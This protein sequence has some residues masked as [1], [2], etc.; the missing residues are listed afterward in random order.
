MNKFFATL[1]KESLMLLRDVPG[2]A[3]LFIMPVLLILV[4]TLA[5][6]NALKFQGSANPIL[7][8]DDHPTQFSKTLATN[9][10]SSGMFSVVRRLEG[11]PI[12]REVANKLLANGSYKL[13]LII[14]KPDDEIVILTDPT[15]QPAY[16]SAVLG[17]LN[18]LIRS[19]QSRYAIEGMLDVTAGTMKPV[20]ESMIDEALANLPP[21]TTHFALKERSAIQPNPIQNNVPGFILFAMF[22]IVIPLS[23]SIINEKN[24]GGYQRLMTLPVNV[25]TILSG[26]IVLYLIVCLLQFGVMLLVGCYAF[27]TFFGLPGLETG[28]H[29]GAITLAT[30]MAAL[31]AIGFGTLVGS[32]A[33]TH[34]QAALFGSVMVVL[35]GIISG[36]FLPIHIMPPPIQ[37]ISLLSPIRWGID[38]YLDIFIREGTIID[39]L[40]RSLLLLAFF[41]FA[42]TISIAIFAK[43]NAWS[44]R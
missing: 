18:F 33:T 1:H 13:C 35:L 19:T 44:S 25:P 29:W 4:V 22:F 7:M 6:E 26:K 37:T 30:L 16:R 32:L 10:D 9:L 24:E 40:P 14:T 41:G 27:P 36:T 38:N 42:M 3:V 39:I 11:K 8:V 5:Q 34:N 28:N 31:A 20:I 15:L 2:L 17:S 12:T 43:R 21:I 23:G